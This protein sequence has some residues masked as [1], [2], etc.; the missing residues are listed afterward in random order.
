M[1]GVLKPLIDVCGKE[2]LS[3]IISIY[4]SLEVKNFLL[5]GGY[6]IEDLNT[7]AKN[8]STQDYTI[9]V[10]NTGI[11]TPTGGRLL[12]C[13]DLIIDDYFFL[14]YGDSVTNYNLSKALSLM[15]NNKADMSI[16]TF[17]KKLEYGVLDI[18]ETSILR[19][20]HEK[21]YSVPINAGFYIL[22]S[23]VFKYI[24]S[25]EDSFEIDVLPRII[26]DKSN[27]IF[28]NELSFWHPM[29]TPDDKDRLSRILLDNPNILFED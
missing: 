24:K 25:L 23:K 26:Q 17:R 27:K 10:L 12:Q 22:N 13:L 14:T 28:V 20:I 11:G 9:T 6:R 3:H 8:N 5:L 18:D 21:T 7:F 15:I 4:K 2:I 19:T 29:D 16:S 1:P